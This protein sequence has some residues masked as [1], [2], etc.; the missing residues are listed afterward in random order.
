[1]SVNLTWRQIQRHFL[2]EKK[3][4]CSLNCSS[5]NKK[6]HIE[7]KLVPKVVTFGP[8]AKT[9]NFWSP[10]INIKLSWLLW[11]FLMYQ[12]QNSLSFVYHKKHWVWNIIENPYNSKGR[13]YTVNIDEFPKWQFLDSCLFPPKGGS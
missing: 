12:I 13:K 8:K 5:S 6:I 1:M 11:F 10:N 2:P 3:Q 4:K 7:H 9:L